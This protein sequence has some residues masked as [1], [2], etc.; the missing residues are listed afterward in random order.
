M[1]Q[2]L[3]TERG[4]PL[5]ATSHWQR[6]V[7]GA[8]AGEPRTEGEAQVSPRDECTGSFSSSEP[9]L[10]TAASPLPAAHRN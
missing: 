7:S 10:R 3:T 4:A 6:V 1:S 9:V 8:W 2:D 5:V